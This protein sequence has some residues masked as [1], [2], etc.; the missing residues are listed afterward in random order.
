[1]NGV[2]RLQRRRLRLLAVA[3]GLA[4][5]CRATGPSGPALRADERALVD[6]YV[7]ITQIEALRGDQPDSV[8]P[9]LDRLAASY[10]ST[11]VQRALALLETDP[12]RWQLVFD[13]IPTRLHELE[14]DPHLR[15]GLPPSIAPE[16]FN[17][18]GPAKGPSKPR[19]P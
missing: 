18:P 1:M 10:D 15:G 7:R 13:A 8:G 11:A 3:A 19:I 5:A 17:A 9:A 14:E 2:K 6:V 12:T 16:S 4:L